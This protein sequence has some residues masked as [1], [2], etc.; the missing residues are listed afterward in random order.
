MGELNFKTGLAVSVVFFTSDNFTSASLIVGKDCVVVGNTLG[1]P[2]VN[3]PLEVFTAGILAEVVGIPNEKLDVG[4]VF[5]SE[6]LVS[7]PNLKEPLAGVMSQLNFRVEDFEL[8]V[9]EVELSVEVFSL[10][11]KGF[12][13]SQAIHLGADLSFLTIQT[14][15][16]H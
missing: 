3:K 12:G 8:E 10:V 2:N 14:S 5:E 15:H 13:F 1:T 6:L 16:S 9:V 11:D 7:I 4:V